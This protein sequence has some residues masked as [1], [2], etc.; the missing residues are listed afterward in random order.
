MLRNNNPKSETKSIE[1]GNSLEISIKNYRFR[2][3]LK[4]PNK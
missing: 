4:I 2:K 1:L 3:H